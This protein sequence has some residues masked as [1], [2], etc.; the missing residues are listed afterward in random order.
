MNRGNYYI[1]PKGKTGIKGLQ[2]NFEKGQN[3]RLNSFELAALDENAKFNEQFEIIPDAIYKKA[4]EAYFKTPEFGKNI[5]QN[6]HQFHYL[7]MHLKIYKLTLQ[8]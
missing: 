2:Q 6:I 1:V 8:T 5:C 4:A 7:K 3:V